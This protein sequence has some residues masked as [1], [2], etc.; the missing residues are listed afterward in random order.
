MGVLG[1]RWIT[2]I[3]VA[4]VVSFAAFLPGMAAGGIL[5]GLL[6]WTGDWWRE[7]AVVTGCALTG[8]AGVAAGSFCLEK[9]SRAVGSTILLVL[10]L[11]FYCYF[12]TSF[13]GLSDEPVKQRFP[14]LFGL[15]LGGGLSGSRMRTGPIPGPCQ[16]M[17]TAWRKNYMWKPGDIAANNLL[18]TNLRLTS[19]LGVGSRFR[20]RVHAQAIVF[21]G[22]RSAKR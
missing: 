3:I 4:C 21:G 9:Q 1:W 12:W 19:A 18:E 20:R 6:S 17:P 10:G 22:G 8:A 13:E 5:V 16:R 14:H 7:G 11:A 2:A 15:A